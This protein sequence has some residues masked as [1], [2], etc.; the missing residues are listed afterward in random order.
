M[1]PGN[2][3]VTEAKKQLAASGEVKIDSLAG[4]TELLI[5][6]D[7]TAN[8]DFIAEDLISQAEHGNRTLCGLVSN[9]SIFDRICE[10]NPILDICQRPQTGAHSAVYAFSRCSPELWTMLSN[11]VKY[12][13]PNI[14]N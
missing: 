11:F 10:K 6:A 2:D 9:S 4:P 12:F 7:E 14:W 8:P 5:A 13:L 3:Y 1:G